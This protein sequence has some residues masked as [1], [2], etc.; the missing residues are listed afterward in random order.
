MSRRGRHRVGVAAGIRPPRRRPDTRTVCV[1]GL[2][3]P[4]GTPRGT[5]IPPRVWPEWHP[6]PSVRAGRS[7]R[8]NDPTPRGGAVFAGRHGAM[9]G[10]VAPGAVRRARVAAR[11]AARAALPGDGSDSR[12]TC[13]HHVRRGP[14][15]PAT[16]RKALRHCHDRGVGEGRQARRRLLS[17]RPRHGRPSARRGAEASVS[18]G[19]AGPSGAPRPPDRGSPTS[20]CR[21]G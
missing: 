6:D 12:T 15:G 18:G 9:R 17:A 11:G 2:R 13:A 1:R 5:A 16:G 8:G 7:H 19:R 10:A 21:R 3:R 20:G 14:P 4:R